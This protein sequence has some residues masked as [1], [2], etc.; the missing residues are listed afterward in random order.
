[1]FGH[2]NKWLVGHMHGDGGGSGSC[3]NKLPDA[4]AYYRSHQTY[5]A[6]AA[7]VCPAGESNDASLL[8]LTLTLTLSFV[9]VVTC[10]V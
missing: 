6:A 9:C 7:F 3:N 1:M 5:A 10:D 2:H 4:Q 8:I